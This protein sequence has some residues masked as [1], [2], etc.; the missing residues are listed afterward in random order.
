MQNTIQKCSTIITQILMLKFREWKFMQADSNTKILDK[1]IQT[2]VN[3]SDIGVKNKETLI[4]R[5]Y[6]TFEIEWWNYWFHTVSKKCKKSNKT[7]RYETKLRKTK[8]AIW[9]GSIVHK[10]SG[11]IW[12]PSKDH[13]QAS[14]KFGS[15][16]LIVPEKIETKCH[17]VVL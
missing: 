15:V 4:M 8:K 6:W 1:M 5:R 16:E 10:D 11:V 14:P 3:A 7:S 12:V 2:C 9:S 13:R 17:F